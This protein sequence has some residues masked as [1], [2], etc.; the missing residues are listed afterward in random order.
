MVHLPGGSFVMGSPETEQ[1]R[2][3][4]EG[5]QR[6][7]EI[8]P[9]AI[10]RYAV[11]NEQYAEFLRA[12]SKVPELD[13]WGDRQY[14][15]ARQPVVGVSW[16]EARAFCQWVGGRLPSEAEWEY[17]ARAGT[18]A[19][20]LTGATPEDLDRFAWYAANSDTRLHPVGEKEPNAWTL[21]D[22]LGNVW[23]WCEDDWHGNYKDAPSDGSAWV[24]QRERSGGRV[25][26]GGAFDNPPENLRV[27]AR[28]GDDAEDRDGDVGFRVVSSGGR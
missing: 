28:Y 2:F 18:V 1:G 5:P 27:A 6:K 14:N 15:Q 17:A 19:P 21:H 9:F 23:E 11:T 8:E 16:R 12:D 4:D 20:Y 22:M 26:R 13:S 24:D 10:S 25:L 7:V 3:D